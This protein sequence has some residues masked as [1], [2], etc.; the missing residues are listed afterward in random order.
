MISNA[1]ENHTVYLSVLGISWFWF[2]GSVLLAQI[3]NLTNVHLSGETTV[4][5]MILAIFTIAV[6]FGSLICERLSGG[7]IEIGIVPIGAFGLSFA[8]IDLYFAIGA[9]EVANRYEWLAF[10]SVPGSP[11][12]L[13]DF[14]LIGFFGGMFIVPLYALI[15]MR[16]PEERRARIIAVNNIINAVFMVAA[17]ILSI[18]LLGVAGFS[19]PELL[20]VSM[21]MN[22]AV[23]VFIFYQVPE[24]TM[25][26]LVWI[27]SHTMYRVTHEGLDKIPEEGP[28]IL[29]C[30]HVTYVDALILAGA[31]RRPIRFVMF[32]PI[33]DIPVLNFVFRHGGAIPIHGEKEDP[34][35]YARAFAEVEMA[36]DKGDLLC[37]FPEGALTLDGDIAQF[38][39][40]VE[41]MVE[42]TPVPVVPLA[43]QGLW[44]SFFSHSGG[45]FR[46][47]S[48][49]WSRVKLVVGDLVP[50]DT[51]TAEALQESVE[52]LRGEH[53]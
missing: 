26:F 50:P 25:R 23:A 41:R 33:Y 12:L 32:K 27:L 1:R 21:L 8:G 28:A 30:N 51:V 47:P 53:A 20:L 36:L 49:L 46:N 24:F 11:R 4:V 29:V 35:T 40:G 37:I 45:V 43:L 15:Q 52:A 7:R 22:V 17:A 39:R 6:A 5:T 44:G 19:I 48:R 42:T 2:M 34:E 13:I 31:V 38:R 16:T 14:A 10:L 18:L 3:P 9:L